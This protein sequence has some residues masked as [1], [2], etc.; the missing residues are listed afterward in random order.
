V[1][2]VSRECASGVTLCVLCRVCCRRSR[3]AVGRGCFVV[4]RA[5]VVAPRR[6][7]RRSESDATPWHDRR[8]ERA[9][10]RCAGERAARSRLTRHVGSGVVASRSSR[11]AR[12]AASG[13]G[14]A[15]RPRPSWAR[16]RGRAHAARDRIPISRPDRGRRGK[17]KAK[18]NNNRTER[19]PRYAWLRSAHRAPVHRA[20]A[21]R[22]RERLPTERELAFIYASHVRILFFRRRH[23][24]ASL[25]PHHVAFE[26]PHL[27]R[28]DRPLEHSSAAAVSSSRVSLTRTQPHN[29]SGV[30]LEDPPQLRV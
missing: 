4:T 2:P 14:S 9:R 17:S 7:S 22:A 8:A 10:R 12:P 23:K 27:K 20:V 3:L 5:R 1:R 6:V 13:A 16:A 15:A 24:L 11:A 21:R 18:S 25:H 28:H 19:T 29:C 30:C 26:A